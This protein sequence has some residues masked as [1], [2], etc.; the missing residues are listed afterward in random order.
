M[1]SMRRSI[2][3]VF[4]LSFV[5]LI[6]TAAF[7]QFD[8]ATV[9]GTVRDNSGAV[10]PG[11]TVT[12][13]N[14]DTGIT[15]TRVSDANGSFEFI[16]VRVGRYKVTAELQG[17]ST[18]FADNVQV[19]VGARQRVELQLTPGSLTDTVEVVGAATRLETDS[20][21]R[22]QVITS[23]QAVQLPLNGRE[24]SA[25][26]LL[27]PGVRLSALNTGSSQ[28]VRE[29][30]FNVNGLR[31]T[32]NNFLLDG[33]D[34][35]AY[36]TSNQGFSNQVMQPSP[37][38]IA[39]FKVV[40]NNMSAEYGRSAGGTINVAYRSGT[41][42]FS[43]AAWE[44]FRDTSLNATGFFKPVS[45]GKPPLSRDQFGFTLGGP[46]A[47][48]HAFFFS[49]YEGFRQNRQSVAFATIPDATQRQGILA[50]TVTNP[51][52]GQTF[53]AGTPIVMSDFARRV[54][55][56]LPDPTSSGAAN[57]YSILQEFTNTT[58]KWNVKS[59][60]QVGE[61]LT[62]FGRFGYRDA[63]LFDQ[64]PIPLPSGGGGNAQTY[65]TNKQFVAGFTWA[66]SGTSLLEGRFGWSRTVAG[67]N[68]AALGT[69]GALEA[70]GI[71]GLPTDP[72]ISGGLPNQII[73]GFSDFGRQAT[74]P[75]WQYPEVWNPKV[76][77]TWLLGRHSLKTGYEFQ[78]IA[79]E[80][81]DVNPLYGRDAYTGQFSRPAGVASSNLYNLADFMFGLRAQ[82]ALSNILVANLR[83]QMHFAY[84]QDDF[85]VNDTLTINLGLRYE[86]ATPH[87]EKDNILSNYDPNNRRMILAS[88][89]SIHDR[90]LITPDRNNFGPRLGFAWSVFPSTVVRGGYG[91][92]FVHF[93]RAG[94]A[95]V[96]S[97]NGPQV[98]NAVANQTLATPTFRT[99]QQ[100]YPDS[101]ADPSAFNPLL[102]NITFMPEDY[103]SSRAQSYYISV[104][105]EVARNM[106][107][108]VAYVGNRADDLLLFANFNQAAPNNPQGTLSLQARRPIQEFSDI[109]YAF[110]G[111]KSR[112]NALQLKYEYR[113]RQGLMLLN[114][115]TWSKS[116]DNGAGSL[117][118]PF[119]NFPAPQ[120]FRNLDADYGTSAYDQPVNNTT[121]VVWALPVGRGKRWL[122]TAGPVTE[123]LL[124]GWILSGINTMTSG[125]PATLQYSPGPTFQV[126]GI[127]QDF[128]GANNYRPNVS[129][130]PYGD[131]SSVTNYLSRETI[132]APTDPSQ[133]FGNAPRNGV[134]GPWFWQM[135]VVAAKDFPLPVRD[136]MRIQVRFEAF[137]VLNRV[138][139]RAPNAN[140]TSSN[141]GTITGTFDARQ[142]QLGIKLTF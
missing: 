12:L 65:V 26:A 79:T 111:G 29:G 46:I 64:P 59:D 72:R 15:T 118:G 47:R 42:S 2:D 97:I 116:R 78:H 71:P 54:L 89:G 34:N 127:Q 50:V 5:L 139:F 81:Q 137:N 37:D 6:S 122:T 105:R 92:S 23:E 94:A 19:A 56:A 140:R 125:E 10:V 25:L 130:D 61:S 126:S 83:Q 7:A 40:T 28:T 52:T 33:I 134:R 44:F 8:T 36:G 1:A 24:Y 27:S 87:W 49:D 11:A 106:I 123:A 115:F 101:F 110:N 53:P 41:N 82:Y 39:E 96:L 113:V 20:S 32:F 128:R 68:P 16:T 38:A 35:N 132:T 22:G 48:N 13:T 120:D 67:K 119:G 90:A 102:A 18:A 60:F 95:N 93:H 51:L 86:Y 121:S 136:Q 31:S 131:R 75:Q 74:N 62:A 109:T 135:D 112:Y 104:Q 124:G 91:M 30:S 58:D 21:Q 17:F 129:G 85:R 117:E 55:S 66:R 4:A 141:Y 77:Y 142:M 3:L 57:N 63:D 133:P 43:G 76:N 45:G 9:V 103:R 84:L 108:D 73:T 69:P 88:D 107:V 80:V 99:T 100:G 70:Y 114:A 138:N 14:L 98:V